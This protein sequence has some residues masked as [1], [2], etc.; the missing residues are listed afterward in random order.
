M[1]VAHFVDGT[2]DWEPENRAARL[3]A[4]PVIVALTQA[5]KGETFRVMCDRQEMIAIAGANIVVNQLLTHTADG[6]LVP[7]DWLQ[8]DDATKERVLRK[9]IQDLAKA[10]KSD[11]EIMQAVFGYTPE[12]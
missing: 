3:G 5:R 6:Y 4:I 12:H 1:A 11:A 2:P 9:A 8:D 10:G 7:I